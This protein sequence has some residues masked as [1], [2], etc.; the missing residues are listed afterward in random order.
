[1]DTLLA[2]RLLPAPG[3]REVRVATVDDHVA[4]LEQRREL[5][6]HGVRRL[7][8]LHHDDQPPRSLQRRD[9]LLGRLGRHEAALAAELLHQR[10]RAGRRPVVHRDRVAVAGEVAGEVAAHDREARDADLR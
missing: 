8:R 7:T 10:V 9:E 5:L 6:D 1:M 2:Q 4:G 3:V